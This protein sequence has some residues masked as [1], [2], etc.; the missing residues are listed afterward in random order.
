MTTIYCCERGKPMGEVNL[1]QGY[2]VRATC[3]E[4]IRAT[5][6]DLLRA[7]SAAWDAASD[8]ALEQL[9]ENVSA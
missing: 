4:C 6:N 8:E 1:Q 9:E 5:D 7:E 2:V 3:A